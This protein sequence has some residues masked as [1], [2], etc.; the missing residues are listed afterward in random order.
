MKTEQSRRIKFIAGV[1]VAA[2]L[3]LASRLWQ[4]QVLRGGEFSTLSYE[5]LLRIEKV[6]S[7]RGIIYDRNG[8]PLVKNSAYYS[9]ALQPEMLGQADLASIAKFLAMDIDEVYRIIKEHGDNPIEPIKL[10]G[11]LSFDEVAF[12]EA[13]LSEHPGLTIAVEQT[14][15]YLYGDVGAHLIGYLGA[16]KP[17]QLEKADFKNVPLQAFVG[18]WGIEKMLDTSLRGAPG[19]RVIE[20]DALG[21]PLRLLREDS[22][23][24]GRDIYLSIDIDLQKQAEKAFGDKVG[25]LV[26]IKP[27]TGEILALVSRPSFDPNL[28]SRGINYDDWRRLSNDQSFPM[29]DRA[30]QSQYPPGSTFKIVTGL[31]A[32]ES[33]SITLGTT[34]YCNGALR[35]GRWTYRCWRRGG[36]GRLAFH[37]A[38]V[39]SCDVYFYRAGEATGIDTIARYAR[40]LGLGRPSGIHLVREKSGLIPD[41]AWKMRVRH[42]P[43]YPGETYHAAIGQGFVLVTPIQLARMISIVANGGSVYDLRVTR[44]EGQPEPREKLNLEER[45]IRAVR[46]ALGGVVSEPRGTGHAARSKVVDIAGKTGTAQVVSNKAIPDGAKEKD[47]PVKLRDHAWFVAFAPVQ[48]PEIALAVFVEHG[49][50]GGSAA[51]PI[52][53]KAIE[54]YMESLSRSN[55]KGKD[56]VAVAQN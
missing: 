14:R 21:R 19:Q 32:L 15:R 3:V 25:A 7:P 24:R 11:G 31:A 8:K 43:W 56:G 23:E 47:L 13:R 1:A 27:S 42:E 2:F 35:K 4:L 36:H 46:K 9:V 41:T 26:A 38:L 34:S 52:A 28:F 55:E 16:L 53:K 30:L 29:L 48:E 33:G 45:N 49:G 44:A 50:H 17:E 18:Q 12:Y 40:L 6:P 54:A 5:N 37:E 39:Q 51:A 22:P 20:V 10:K